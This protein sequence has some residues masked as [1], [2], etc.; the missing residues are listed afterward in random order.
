MPFGF[1][2]ERSLEGGAVTI[3]LLYDELLLKGKQESLGLGQGQPD[4][5]FDGALCVPMK[6]QEFNAARRLLDL[7]G[8][9][10]KNECAC[11]ALELQLGDDW[12]ASL[13]GVGR[14]SHPS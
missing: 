9:K 11:N 4:I 12:P 13:P 6:T 2:G 8:V 1:V 3:Q 5:T 14:S 10:L 7:G